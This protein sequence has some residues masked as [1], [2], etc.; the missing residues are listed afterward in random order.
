MASLRSRVVEFYTGKGVAGALVSVGGINV[1]TDTNGDFAITVSPG[2]WRLQVVHRDF[3]AYVTLVNLPLNIAYSL[4]AIRIRSV[5][6][7]L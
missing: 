7:P 1:L 2:S 6:R 4:P 5:V 3:Q